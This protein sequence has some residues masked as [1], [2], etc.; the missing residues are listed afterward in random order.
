MVLGEV[1]DALLYKFVGRHQLVVQRLLVWSLG[2]E[3]FDK[4]LGLQ[5]LVEHLLYHFETDVLGELIFRVGEELLI[6]E[7]SLLLQLVVV[8][9]FEIEAVRPHLRTLAL[10]SLGLGIH[11]LRSTLVARELLSKLVEINLLH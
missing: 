8:L 6:E 1:L 4:L 9:A 11:I 3:D 2:L 7:A 5:A 10:I